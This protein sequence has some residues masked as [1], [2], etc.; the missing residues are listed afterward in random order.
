MTSWNYRVIKKRGS[1]DGEAT[2]QIHEVY[3]RQDGRIDCWTQQP[4]EPLGVNE[5]QL[6]NDIQSFLAAFRQPILEERNINGRS[7]LVEERTGKLDSSLVADYRDRSARASL[8]LYQMLGNHLLLRQNPALRLAYDRVDRALAD[9]HDL[10]AGS[11]SAS[12][13]EAVLASIR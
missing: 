1:Q 8:Y 6:R 12:T 11:A 13:P 2:Y 10:A 4:V 5:A 3:Y 7:V 9:L